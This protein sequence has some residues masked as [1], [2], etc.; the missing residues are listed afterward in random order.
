MA[1]VETAVMTEVVLSRVPQHFLS[2]T[3]FGPHCRTV[4]VRTTRS[5]TWRLR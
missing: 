2:V 3:S 4:N 1:L 5:V